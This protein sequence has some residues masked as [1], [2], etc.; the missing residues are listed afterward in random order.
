MPATVAA[1]CWSALRLDGGPVTLSSL[2]SSRLVAFCSISSAVAADSVD[3]LV[4]STCITWPDFV[5]MLC[6]ETVK[7]DKSAYIARLLLVWYN[8]LWLAVTTNGLTVV[9][10]SYIFYS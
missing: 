2:G 5:N 6:L 10:Y 1:I 8:C 7:V 3:I 9:H 4:H